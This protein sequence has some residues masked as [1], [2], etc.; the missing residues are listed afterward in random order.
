MRMNF[1]ILNIF[2]LFLTVMAVSVM[3]AATAQ[4]TL[5]G[6]FLDDYTY[7]YEMNPALD[8]SRNFI[9]MPGLGNINVATQGNLHV[10]DVLFNV[11]GRTTTFLNPMV[12]VREVM[13]GIS[14]KNRIGA[15]LK[16]T[17]LAAGFKAMGGYNTISINA[18]SGLEAQL[19]RS[20]FSLAKEG[21]VNRT[22]DITDVRAYGAAYAE[23]ALGHSHALG[24]KWR[25]G[26]TLKLLVGGGYL[27]ASMKYARLILGENDWSV[28]ADADVNANV[29]GLTYKTKLNDRTGNRY[30]S[31]AD[32]DGAGINGFGAALD[33]GATY[34]PGRDWTLSLAVVDLGFIKWNNNMLA[35]TNG[36]KTFHTDRYIFNVDDDAENSFKNEWERM[37]DGLSSL[38]ELDDMGDTGSKTRMLGATINAG[39]E[40]TLP[41]WRRMKFGLVNTTR[42]QGEYSYTDFRL[43]ANI[44][45]ARCFDASVNM[46]AGTFGVGFGWLLNLHTKG[47]NLFVGMDRT[48]FRLARQYVPLNSNS[49]VNFGMNFP[50]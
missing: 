29:K 2:R 8:N 21:V 31:G 1:K 44:A 24:S 34:K 22:Y 11:G 32:I 47:F 39:V 35:S 7:R 9:S 49:S 3:T 27:D 40:Y 15:N 26:G 37:K 25:I 4:N 13:D 28:I 30:V 6:Y 23:L 46:S 45:P 17:L 41:V 20:L 12:G 14:E 36:P 10:N 5:S 38:Y 18:R 19:P 16:I 50:F 43:S 42:I 33:L 48:P